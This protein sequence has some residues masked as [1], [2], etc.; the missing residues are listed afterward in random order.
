MEVDVFVC[1]IGVIRERK[2]EQKEK[3][4]KT[5][6]E[7]ALG[8]IMIELNRTRLGEYIVWQGHWSKVIED[9]LTQ[10]RCGFVRFQDGSHIWIEK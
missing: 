7:E 1:S 5:A 8:A 6:D 10:A 4:K 2:S 3:P 9:A